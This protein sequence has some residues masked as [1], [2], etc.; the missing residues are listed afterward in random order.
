M[1]A[2]VSKPIDPPTLYQTIAG[3]LPK[4]AEVL[5]EWQADSLASHLNAQALA[6]LADMFRTVGSDNIARLQALAAAGD[7]RGVEQCAHDLKGMGGYW[8]AGTLVAHAHALSSAAKA[9]Q[10]DRV[11]ALAAQLEGVWA[12]TMA[13]VERMVAAAA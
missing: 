4:G 7:V 2:H 13:D 1:N 12:A 10:L 9:D 6:T 5:T 11:R 8:G 3:L